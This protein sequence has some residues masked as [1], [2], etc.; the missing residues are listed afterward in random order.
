MWTSLVDAGRDQGIRPFGVEAQRLLRLEKGHLIVGHDTDALTNP[1]EANVDWAIAKKKRFF[2]GHRS[3]EILKQK[4]LARRLVGLRLDQTHGGLPAKECH[5]IIA[6]GDI[7]GRVTSVA[8]QSTLGYPIAL[9]FVR[10]EMAS[11]AARVQIRVDDGSFVE[12]RV[13]ALP[14][15]DATNSR[16]T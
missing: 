8:L 13:T 16:Q 10:P 5:L 15:Y 2:V 12:A 11:E 4:P 6:D 7:A 3:L 14:F 1:L 9:A